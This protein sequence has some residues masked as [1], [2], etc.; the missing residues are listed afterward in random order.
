MIRTLAGIPLGVD[1]KRVSLQSELQ[2]QA[3]RQVH[4]SGPSRPAQRYW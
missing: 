1:A 3:V 2:N 4:A